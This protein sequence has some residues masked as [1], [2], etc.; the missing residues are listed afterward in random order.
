M[1]RKIK[2]K[3]N[4]QKAPRVRSTTE[5]HSGGI[6]V[7]SGHTGELSDS[8]NF[9]VIGKSLFGSDGRSAFYSV[10]EGDIG[11]TPEATIVPTIF[12]YR[13][14]MKVYLA[15]PILRECVDSYRTNIESYGFDYE[16]IGPTGQQDSRASS[17]ERTRIERLISS[18][19][20]DGRP[21]REH[22]E[23]SRVDKEVLGNRAFEVIEDMAGRVVT[24]DHVPSITLRMTKQDKEYT[25]AVTY[26]IHGGAVKTR[27]HFRS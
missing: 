22:R 9:E 5:G 19:T 14:L 16:Y 11:S 2:L 26:D 17:N 8:T 15:S 18:L 25:D 23:D 21:L 27:R 12:S 3:S 1:A 24:F 7:S 4:K 13:D 6:H 10:V 20:T